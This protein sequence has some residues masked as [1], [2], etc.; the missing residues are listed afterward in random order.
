M[1]D[2]EFRGEDELAGVAERP[3]LRWLRHRRLLAFLWLQALDGTFESMVH[4][5]DAFFSAAHLQEFIT[6]G[7]WRDA[8]AYLGRFLQLDNDHLL[9][10]EAKVLHRFLFAHKNL[11]EILADTKEG[12]A[13]TD[14]FRKYRSHD[15][16]VCHGTLRSQD[17]FHHAH[18]APREGAH[19]VVSFD[20]ERAWHRAAKIACDMVHRIPELKGV[21]AMPAGPLKPHNVLPIHTSSIGKR[22]RH[23]KHPYQPRAS[24]LAKCYLRKRGSLLSSSPS[25]ELDNE[26]FTKVANW[27]ADILDESLQAGRPLDLHQKCTLPTSGKQGAS[28]TTKHLSQGGCNAKSVH[29][30]FNP[31]AEHSSRVGCNADRVHQDFNP[32]KN[33]RDVTASDEHNHHP[34]RQWTNGV[35]AEATLL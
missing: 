4:E 35:S 13:L 24:S 2:F 22:Y 6:Q 19:E 25:K 32:K 5:T 12:H 1:L 27:I 10:V 34:K 9:S 33:S 15:S 14:Y 28:G 29:E 8:I 23:K 18:R 31:R 20:W 17:T 21:A 16:I 7:W 11:A 26:L 30:D 3:I